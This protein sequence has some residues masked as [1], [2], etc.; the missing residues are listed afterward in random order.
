ML[1]SNDQ[2]C[3]ASIYNRNHVITAANCMLT[4]N[5][6][7]WPPNQFSIISGSNTINFNNPRIP[8]EAIYVHPQYNPFTLENDIA[9]VRTQIDFS[10]PQVLPP[11]I[12]QVII[13]TRI[14]EFP[15]FT[16]EPR[17]IISKKLSTH[18]TA[19]SSLGTRET[20]FSKPSPFRSSIAMNAM[21][22][23]STLAEFLSRCCVREYWEQ[24][25]AFAWSTEV[26]ACTATIDLKE[27]WAQDSPAEPL[28]TAP[29]FTR[30]C[31]FTFH[32]LKSNYIDKIF[33]HQW[34]RPMKGCRRAFFSCEIIVWE[35]RMTKSCWS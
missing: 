15:S 25:V 24:E 10:F 14:G 30:K 11:L 32:G 23:L 4:A 31:G 21:R 3:G 17:G 27:F 26:P 22:F 13:S 8:V 33:R 16:T 20:I 35:L 28:R 2:F 19:M 7:L 29:A 9:V 6:L 34:F 5:H 12:A 1:P 18:K